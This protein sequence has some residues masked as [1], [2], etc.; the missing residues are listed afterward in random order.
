MEA[1]QGA[2]A[3][4]A[5]RLLNLVCSCLINEPKYYQSA[6]E[7]KRQIME[8]A[9]AVGATEPELLL[10]FALYVRDDLNIRST[11]NFLAALA[12]NTPAAHSHLSKYFPTL[13]RLP[14]DLLE[15]VDFFFALPDSVRCLA[16]QSL[17]APVRRAI[18]ERFGAFDVYAL[19]K[20]NREGSAKRKAAK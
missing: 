17:P 19:G 13:L 18:K 14:T 3:N 6:D 1:R 20:H 7:R 8:C 2:I 15:M 11:A 9:A 12:C 16:S 5:L 4:P 10:K